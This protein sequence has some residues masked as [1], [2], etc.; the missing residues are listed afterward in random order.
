M[1]G[2]EAPQWPLVTATRPFS[3]LPTLYLAFC[4]LL[5]VTIEEVQ[6]M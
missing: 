2:S 1:L 4:I 3:H 6:P 5:C